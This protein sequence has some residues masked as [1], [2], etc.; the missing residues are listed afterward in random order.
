M[1]SNHT[2]NVPATAEWLLAC[3]Q[4][5]LATMWRPGGVGPTIKYQELWGMGWSCGCFRNPNSWQ[6]GSLGSPGHWELVPTVPP[7]LQSGS[8]AP[9]VA[10]YCPLSARYDLLAR[11]RRGILYIGLA[12]VTE[13]A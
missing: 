1:H 6:D 10:A 8:P 4:F 11:E 7:A 12:A 9:P 3:C 5:A 2:H 13:T